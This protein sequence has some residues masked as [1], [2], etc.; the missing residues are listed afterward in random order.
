MC[1]DHLFVLQYHEG[2]Q[3]GEGWQGE[4]V[5]HFSVWHCIGRLCTD[6]GSRMSQHL[7]LIDALSSNLIKKE[8]ENKETAGG[9][10]F[11]GLDITCFWCLAKFS[12]LLEAIKG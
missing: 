11:T 10:F 1:N 5:P 6:M 8:K 9:L 4:M 7:I 12:Q 2:W 3:V